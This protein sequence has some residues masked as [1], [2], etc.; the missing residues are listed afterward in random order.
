MPGAKYVPETA[1]SFQGVLI[2]TD[3]ERD[4]RTITIEAPCGNSCIINAD[5]LV[6]RSAYFRGALSGGFAESQS[7][8]FSLSEH[9]TP[10]TLF[11]F[12][13]WAHSQDQRLFYLDTI[14][15]KFYAV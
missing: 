2:L 6:Q 10:W 8:R 4:T 14:K 12:S 3:I 7:L 5:V 9:A 11:V 15:P 1:H 13:E